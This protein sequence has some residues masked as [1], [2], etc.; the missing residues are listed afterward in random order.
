MRLGDMIPIIEQASV[1]CFP[2]EDSETGDFLGL[3]RLDHIRPFLFNPALYDAIIVGEIMDVDVPA[4]S[5][6]DDVKDVI[7]WMDRT[8]ADSLPVVHRKKFLGMVSKTTILDRYRK[9]LIV[10]SYQEV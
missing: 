3:I 5:P 8:R 10:Q 6:V 2:V 1:N 9:E 4:V 7:E